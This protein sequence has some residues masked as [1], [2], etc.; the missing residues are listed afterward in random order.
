MKKD[1]I[2]TIMEKD[3]I[4]LSNAERKELEEFCTTESEYIH[5]KEVFISVEA[6][7]LDNPTPRKETKEKLV[8]LFASTYP[9]AAPIWYSS[10]GAFIVRKNQPI[11]RQPL[12]Q[13]A[14]VGLLLLLIYPIWNTS[15]FKDAPRNEVASVEVNQTPIS[16]DTK[17]EVTAP[18][19]NDDLVT[20][21]KNEDSSPKTATLIA[22]I[23]KPASMD[24]LPG[25]L[26]SDHP[27]GVYVAY[28]QPASD[29]PEMLDLLTTTF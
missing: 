9:K 24:A 26:D 3:F 18:D 12:M 10:V 22:S 4:E 14:A 2:D 5:M 6:M 23:E 27:D 29:A 11:H 13:I 17:T 19:N 25:R 7:P 8:E 15:E 1:L 21:K 20:D 16:K 28:S